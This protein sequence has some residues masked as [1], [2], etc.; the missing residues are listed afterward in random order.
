M[1]SEV[2]SAKEFVRVEFGPESEQSALR[3]GFWPS[4]HVDAWI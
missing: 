4:Y 2:A 3:T 1:V